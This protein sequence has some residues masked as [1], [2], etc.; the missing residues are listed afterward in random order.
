MCVL[1]FSPDCT[2]APFIST[3]TIT[4]TLL[5]LAATSPY[6]P[7][8]T[9]PHR[10]RVIEAGT[11]TYPP[12]L[13]CLAYASQHVIKDLC[14]ALTFEVCGEDEGERMRAVCGQDEGETE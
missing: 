8:L 6:T 12:P 7:T 3:L 2:N 5:T 9:P 10:C 1:S 11:H 13:P 14:A 4:L